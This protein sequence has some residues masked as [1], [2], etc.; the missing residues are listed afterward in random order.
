[1][2]LIGVFLDRRVVAAVVRDLTVV[3]G[4]VQVTSYKLQGTRYSYKLQV[5]SYKYQVTSY[6][7][8]RLFFKKLKNKFKC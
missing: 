3:V 7:D 4:V 2:I 5:A 1:M 6:N 8:L